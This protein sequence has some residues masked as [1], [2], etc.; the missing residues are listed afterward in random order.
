MVIN[1][2]QYLVGGKGM[3][4]QGG[5]GGGGGGGRR[6]EEDKGEGKGKIQKRQTLVSLVFPPNETVIMGSHLPMRSCIAVEVRGCFQGFGFSSRQ[7]V[8][9]TDSF[10]A[11]EVGGSD[12]TIFG[13]CF[14]DRTF[15]R[16]AFL[17]ASMPPP[18]PQW[19]ANQI[20]RLCSCPNKSQG[21]SLF[22]SL[23]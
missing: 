23:G 20:K 1:A 17:M 21:C 15:T 19:G 12:R 4:V 8:P 7:G 9:T 14:T 3:A 5:G 2:D 11:K 13:R 6:D 18:T 16:S 10:R 22:S